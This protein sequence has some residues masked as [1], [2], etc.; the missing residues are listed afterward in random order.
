MRFDVRKKK[1]F[2]KQNPQEPITFLIGSTINDKREME[3]LIK[4]G[5]NGIQT[6]YPK[7]LTN[8]VKEFGLRK[9]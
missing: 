4:K 3:C 6:D 5:V 7:R 1:T 2:N 8:L 9:E